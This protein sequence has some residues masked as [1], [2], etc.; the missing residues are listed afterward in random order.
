M[1]QVRQIA[2]AGFAL[3][4]VVEGVRAVMFGPGD[5]DARPRGHDLAQH[6]QRQDV[7]VDEHDLHGAR[8][9]VAAGRGWCLLLAHDGAWLCACSN[10]VFIHQHSSVSA[11]PDWRQTM[12]FTETVPQDIPKK[13]Q[14]VRCAI[15]ICLGDEVPYRRKVNEKRVIVPQSHVCRECQYRDR[16]GI[17]TTRICLRI[18]PRR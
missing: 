9:L 6:L 18:P 12:G 5:G 3:S 16:V 7:V 1:K 11:P 4:V 13:R 17:C 8:R 10:T 2:D 14:N 15:M